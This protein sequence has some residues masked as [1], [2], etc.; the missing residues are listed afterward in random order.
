MDT[1]GR[2][3][4][5]GFVHALQLRLVR[6]VL[7]TTFGQTS[8]PYIIRQSL[9]SVE[10]LALQGVLMS[11][12]DRACLRNHLARAHVPQATR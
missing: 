4:Q 6:V 11:V 2:A 10:R 12:F 7:F 1:R 8:G 9:P 5:R 3:C